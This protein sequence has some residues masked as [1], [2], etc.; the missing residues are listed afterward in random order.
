MPHRLPGE[1]KPQVAVSDHDSRHRRESRKEKEPEARQVTPRLAMNIGRR[2]YCGGPSN[3]K[4][5]YCKYGR[6]GHHGV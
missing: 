5:W 1:Q 6:Y 4:D 2:M 3:C